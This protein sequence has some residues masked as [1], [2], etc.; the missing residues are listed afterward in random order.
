MM[1]DRVLSWALK[2]RLLTH[3][4]GCATCREVL[5]WPDRPAYDCDQGWAAWSAWQWQASLLERS[6]PWTN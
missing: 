6:E 4:S 2:R 3:I 1:T 5:T